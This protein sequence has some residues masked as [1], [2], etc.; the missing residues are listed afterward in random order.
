M[1]I[2]NTMKVSASGLAAE[3]VRMDL[4]ADNI[5]NVETTRTAQGGPYKRKM[6]VF[7][8]KNNTSFS[9]MLKNETSRLLGVKVSR[10]VEDKSPS[11]LVYDP[12]H[13]DAFTEGDLEGYL[14][15]PNVD[16]VKEMVDMIGA[17][18]AYEAN[19]TVLN[20]AKTMA[21][22]ALEIGRG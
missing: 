20:G 9:Q 22:K 21:T 6:A 17:S 15:L 5:A 1:S 16:I 18:R 13:P 19:V 10:I 11:K 14:A 4:I 2:F 3:R 8:T 12:N 7:A